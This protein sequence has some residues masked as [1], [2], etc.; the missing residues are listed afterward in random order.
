[1][2]EIVLGDPVRIASFE[3][4]VVDGSIFILEPAPIISKSAL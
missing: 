2:V 1:L 4:T 3:F